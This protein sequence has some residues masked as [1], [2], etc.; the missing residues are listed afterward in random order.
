M[1][2]ANRRSLFLKAFGPLSLRGL[3]VQ[4]LTSPT[5]SCLMSPLLMHRRTDLWG[6]DGEMF[7]YWSCTT[8]YTS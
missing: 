4:Y 5:P 1:T 8:S 7:A 2:P 3:L 6:P